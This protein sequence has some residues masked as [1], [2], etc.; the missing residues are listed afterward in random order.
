MGTFEIIVIIELAILITIKLVKDKI[1]LVGAT[2]I[3]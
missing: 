2:N 1:R 3:A